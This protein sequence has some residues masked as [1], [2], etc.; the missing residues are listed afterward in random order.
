MTIKK[1]IIV[2]ILPV[3]FIVSIVG[4]I[5]LSYLLKVEINQKVREL[6]SIEEQHK[7]LNENR[8]ITLNNDFLTKEMNT[9]AVESF[10]CNIYFAYN[11]NS[12]N[13]SD[14]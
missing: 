3:I 10:F 4:A 7:S 11:Y 14:N 5:S 6:V 8:E 13:C 12:N 1:K 9:Y 2:R